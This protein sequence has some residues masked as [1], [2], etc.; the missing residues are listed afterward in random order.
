[1]TG[2]MEWFHNCGRY[3]QWLVYVTL[4]MLCLGAAPVVGQIAAAAPVVRES[5]L[6]RVEAPAGLD[7][8]AL[9]VMSHATAAMR[10]LNRATGDALLVPVKF[11]VAADERAFLALA[12]GE[13]EQSL[14]VSLGGQQTV[15]ISRPAM[16][17]SNPDKI[18]QVLAHEL[19]HVY[20]DV[21]CKVP[22]PRWVHEGVAQMVAGEWTDA[23]G[24]GAMALAAYTGGLIPLSD[25]VATFPRDETQRTVA[26]AEAYSAMRY[27]VQTA[28]GNSLRN[29]LE[30][31]R[32]DDGREYLK[33]LS[34][35]VELAALQSRWQSE[36]KSPLFVTTLLLGSGF[37]WGMAALLAVVAYAVVRR[38]GKKIRQG[39]ATEEAM[40][41]EWGEPPHEAEWIEGAPDADDAAWQEGDGEEWKR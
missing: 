40:A 14:A 19:A 15:V 8:Y 6:I 35:G 38:R 30:K 7:N 29:F 22:V 33:S 1:M 12:G 25:L 11:I 26:Y 13:G 28:H 27:L 41:A 23:P 9:S 18:Q 17:K 16:M 20:L 39:W 4:C 31:I 34:E 37:F 3:R 21:R 5:G 32:G 36:L 24:D 10:T 2:V